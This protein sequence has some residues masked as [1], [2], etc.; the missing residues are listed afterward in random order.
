MDYSSATFFPQYSTLTS[1]NLAASNNAF[2]LNPSPQQQQRSQ[3]NNP[4]SQLQ[5]NMFYLD[6][7]DAKLEQP[8]SNDIDHASFS[9]I[10]R[11][12]PVIVDESD[13]F[14]DDL[15][16][17]GQQRRIPRLQSDF[18]LDLSNP[19]FLDPSNSGNSTVSPFYHGMLIVETE[20]S[21]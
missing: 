6:P 15:E 7:F 20:S 8:H 21:E 11:E 12:F 16:V 4:V 17:N 14:L 5:Q 10:S 13:V 3:N 19:D 9:S 2:S 1:E 18:D